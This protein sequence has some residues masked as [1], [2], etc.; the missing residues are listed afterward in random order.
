M[1]LKI[2]RGP[3]KPQA[4]RPIKHFDRP[5][6]G[7]HRRPPAGTPQQPSND[8]AREALRTAKNPPGVDPTQQKF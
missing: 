7:P 8:L 4:S 3:E 2:V 6:D 5:A 1:E